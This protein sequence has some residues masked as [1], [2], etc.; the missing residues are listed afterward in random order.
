MTSGD[1]H[2][3]SR[4]LSSASQHQR[5]AHAAGHAQDCLQQPCNIIIIII[6]IFFF[7]FFFSSS[8][9][10][11]HRCRGLRVRRYDLHVLLVEHGKCCTRCAKNSK[12]RKEVVGPCPLG[13]TQKLAIQLRAEGRDLGVPERAAELMSAGDDG[14]MRSEPG[15][16]MGSKPEPGEGG[17]LG[18]KAEVGGGKA[19]GVKGGEAGGGE[20]SEGSEGSE[21]GEGAVAEGVK[22]EGG[23]E[24]QDEPGG[25]ERQAGAPKAKTRAG[26]SK[27]AAKGGKGA[28][29]KAATRA[30]SRPQKKAKAA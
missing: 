7:F 21:G 9:S 28:K 10:F 17:G 5:L 27:G 4:L 29:G 15:D 12:P 22:S 1:C 30:S 24:Q 2:S 16:G 20:G 3:A 6:I 11:F 26:N 25:S 18:S 13:D 14:G 23:S 19:G 8:S